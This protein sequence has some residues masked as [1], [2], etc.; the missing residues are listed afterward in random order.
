MFDV[1]DYDSLNRV[2]SLDRHKVEKKCWKY[3]KVKS[4]TILDIATGNRRFSYL[5][6]RLP[7]KIIGLDISAGMLEVGVKK[8]AEKT[9]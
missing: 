3:C 8:I 2:I 7:Q 1:S 9:V 4:D 5:M 6:T